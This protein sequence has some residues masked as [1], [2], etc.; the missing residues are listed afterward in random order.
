M[1]DGIAG[2]DAGGDG[3]TM[4]MT[5]ED[6]Q[7]VKKVVAWRP[8]R[9]FVYN[10]YEERLHVVEG[11]QV[12]L[13]CFPLPP[14]LPQLLFVPFPVACGRNFTLILTRPKQLVQQAT[15]GDSQLLPASQGSQEEVLGGKEHTAGGSG[16]AAAILD[17]SAQEG[18]TAAGTG[19]RPGASLTRLPEAITAGGDWSE[20]ESLSAS[21]GEDM[22][23]DMMST[24]T[25]DYFVPPPPQPIVEPS[26]ETK[27]R[28]LENENIR[29]L[30]ESLSLAAADRVANFWEES[31]KTVHGMTDDELRAEA[32]AEALAYHHVHPKC[33]ETLKCKG[34]VPSK[35]KVRLLSH[36][37]QLPRGNA[38]HL[39][40]PPSDLLLRVLRIPSS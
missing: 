27:Q 6:G 5:M 33:K 24:G 38:C 22:D 1:S 15:V 35:I 10:S 13:G 4:D 14:S 21:E 40:W 16:G 34:F 32:L 20:L 2:T 12:C 11:K 9:V 39:G 23:E 28:L 26:S 17:G 8:E 29:R 30:I 36:H 25:V 7:L 19:V 31:K 37:H 18:A 3:A